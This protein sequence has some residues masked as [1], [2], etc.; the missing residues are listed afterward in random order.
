LAEKAAQATALPAA[1]NWRPWTPQVQVNAALSTVNAAA[2]AAL[3]ATEDQ[4]PEAGAA[5]EG[6]PAT[7]KTWSVKAL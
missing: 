4:A 1:D 6:P 3:Q 5:A 2:A 7:D